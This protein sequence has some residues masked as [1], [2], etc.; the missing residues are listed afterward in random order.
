MKV[1]A[2]LLINCSFTFLFTYYFCSFVFRFLFNWNMILIGL[3][4]AVTINFFELL[5]IVLAWHLVYVNTES[6]HWVQN[7]LWNSIS[8]CHLRKIKQISD[9]LV[10][11]NF[12]IQGVIQLSIFFFKITRVKYA[13]VIA[14]MCVDKKYLWKFEENL[15]F[16]HACICLTHQPNLFYAHCTDECKGAF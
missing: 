16:I 4:C 10:A 13:F 14:E 7:A 12:I 8:D 6:Q 11:E 3:H 5:D 15:V 9:G 1:H 2:I